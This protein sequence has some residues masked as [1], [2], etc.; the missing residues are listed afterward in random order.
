MR[1]HHVFAP[2][3]VDDSAVWWSAHCRVVDTDWLGWSKIV[4]SAD[5]N[6]VSGPSEDRRG[7]DLWWSWSDVKDIT[8]E[9]VTHGLWWKRSAVVFVFEDEERFPV[10]LMVSS[11]HWWGAYNPIVAVE[12][13]AWLRERRLAASVA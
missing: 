12:T 5:D 8:V 13:A 4:V 3:T 7:R 6:G 1:Y 11:S 2:T 10:K 9:R